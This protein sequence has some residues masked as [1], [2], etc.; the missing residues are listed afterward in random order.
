MRI[1][2]IGAGRIGVTV[3]SQLRKNP[4]IT[5]IVS[6][7][8]LQPLAVQSGLIEKVDY[9]AN[10]T[11]VNVNELAKRIRPDLILIS[12]LDGEHSLGRLEGGRALVDALNYEITTA[13]DFPCL[14]LSQ[15]NT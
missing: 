1:W 11:P 8:S 5:V 13:S 2:L 3:L 7:P 15:S 6:D 14:I 9:V 10:V 12:T 4:D